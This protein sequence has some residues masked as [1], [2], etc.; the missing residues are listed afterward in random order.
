MFIVSM[1]YKPV[2]YLAMDKSYLNFINILFPCVLGSSGFLLI[3][4]HIYFCDSILNIWQNDCLDL[5]YVNYR[6]V[7]STIDVFRYIETEYLFCWSWGYIYVYW[8]L[9]PYSNLF[10]S[11]FCRNV[12][13]FLDELHMYRDD[14]DKFIFIQMINCLLVSNDDI[15]TQILYLT[16]WCQFLAC[17]IPSRLV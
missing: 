17:Y 9:F 5:L 8:N 15:Y 10:F 2:I 12:K 13:T 4:N 16:I 3:N 14:Y 6:Y 1:M 11:S 7:K